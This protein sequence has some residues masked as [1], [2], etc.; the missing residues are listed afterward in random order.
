MSL[1]KG[2][3]TNKAIDTL[4]ACS[5]TNSLEAKEAMTA[6][7]Q[8]GAPA[9]PKLISALGEAPANSPV[10]SLLGSMLDNQTLKYYVDGLLDQDN[11][12]VAGTMRVLAN[13]RQYDPNRLFELFDDP[14]IPKNVLVQILLSHREKLN[15]KTL[16]GMLTRVEKNIR[17]MILK[18]LDEV[19]DESHLSDLLKYA[20]NQD[21]NIRYNII[22]IISRFHTETV[23]DALL[24]ALS[25]Q[26]KNV[27]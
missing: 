7:K 16:L 20:D 1:I 4:L 18:L 5:N 9:V 11:R 19:A 6:L 24:R 12:I 2:F 15:A 23:R 13:S 8:I 17:L 3:K 26:N 14:D 21:L 10:E 25:D 22:R 27:R